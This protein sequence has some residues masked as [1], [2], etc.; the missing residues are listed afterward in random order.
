MPKYLRNRRDL[1][2]DFIEAASPT[3]TTDV[4]ME[5]KVIDLYQPPLTLSI[6]ASI[7]TQPVDVRW[8]LDFLYDPSHRISSFYS[9]LRSLKQSHLASHLIGAPTLR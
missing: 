3:L 5:G 2:V 6:C 4:S 8:P 1:S 9:H 7:L